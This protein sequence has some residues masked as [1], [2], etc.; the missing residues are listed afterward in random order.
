MKIA[1]L[2]IASLR[3]LTDVELAPNPSL[4]WLV[5]P[6]GSGKTSLL[7]AIHLLSHGHSF[8]GGA[9]DS[10]IRRGSAGFTILAEIEDSDHVHAVGMARS[11]GGWQLRVDGQD[12]PTLA[13]VL[14]RCATICFE[15]GTHELIAGSAEGRRRFLDW[16]VF[17]VEHASLT[18]WRPYRRVLRQRNMLLRT[19]GP[20]EQLE[21]WEAELERF[22]APIEQQRQNYVELLKSHVGLIARRFLP[23]LGNARFDYY[24]GWNTEQP[25]SEVLAAQ[26]QGD[27]K[28]GYTRSGPHRADWRLIFQD[29]PVR[30]HLSRGQVKLAALA[31]TLAQGSIYAAQLGTWPIMCVDDLESELDLPHRQLVFQH[32]FSSRAQIWLTATQLPEG[33]HPGLPRTVFHVE[34][35]H[36]RVRDLPG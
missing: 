14:R 27:A 33:S 5:G 19:D 2:R 29:A 23:E 12:V 21:L 1:K 34:R 11:M 3:C 4:N 20:A 36:V 13:A 35:G 15:P 17:H 8:R 24:S 25:L 7:E 30:E 9:R 28:C 32:L 10:L 18:P 31:C 6:N 16:G 26:R 22:A